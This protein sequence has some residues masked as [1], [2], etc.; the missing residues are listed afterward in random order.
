MNFITNLNIGSS[1]FI[2]T[3][4][5]TYYIDI[6]NN[7]PN[8]LIPNL[9]DKSI[10]NGIYNNIYSYDYEGLYFS[11]S[12]NLTS[13]ILYINNIK[14]YINENGLLKFINKQ[15]WIIPILSVGDI[16]FKNIQFNPVFI[17]DN[18]SQYNLINEYKGFSFPKLPQTWYSNICSNFSSKL[19]S[20][21]MIWGQGDIPQEYYSICGFAGTTNVQAQNPFTNTNGPY[22]ST[23]ITTNNNYASNSGWI[24]ILAGTYDPTLVNP[25]YLEDD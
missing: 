4:F 23:Y 1:S 17:T 10:Y 6:N 8:S 9:N 11:T 12:D 2:A 21:Q 24:I 18:L 3:D 5:S 15:L 20:F 16:I 22:Y 14:S 25:P 7:K 13:F 19:F